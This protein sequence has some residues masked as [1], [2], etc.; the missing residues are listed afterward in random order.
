MGRSGSA[1]CVVKNLTLPEESS[2]LGPHPLGLGWGCSLTSCPRNVMPHR[3]A[4]L[5]QGELGSW[6]TSQRDLR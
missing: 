3:R 6:I 4:F 5:V 2:G 1:T